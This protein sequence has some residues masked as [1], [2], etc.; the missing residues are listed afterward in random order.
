MQISKSKIIQSS[1]FILLSII[2]LISF[3]NFKGFHAK[4]YNK[5][6]DDIDSLVIAGTF[7][8]SLKKGQSTEY[9][10]F[11][12]FEFADNFPYEQISGMIKNKKIVQDYWSD[13][14]EGREIRSKGNY[15][16]DLKKDTTLID[17]TCFYLVEHNKKIFWEEKQ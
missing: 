12:E 15:F 8:G 3:L 11:K 16:F 17:T 6:G 9:I 4:F 2:I 10:S 1:L 14:G 13:C 5:T 7:I